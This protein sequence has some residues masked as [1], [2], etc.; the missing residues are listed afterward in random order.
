MITD[1]QK[2][3]F[4]PEPV[5][6]QQEIKTPI[7]QIGRTERPLNARTQTNNRYL[8]SVVAYKSQ[9]ITLW[10]EYITWRTFTKTWNLMFDSVPDGI[11]IP[12]SWTYMILLTVSREEN[13]SWDRYIEILKNTEFYKS[14]FNTVAA[15]DALLYKQDTTII[16]NFT[17]WDYLEVRV[18]QS[19]AA[20]LNAW[21]RFQVVKLS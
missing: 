18:L 5:Q 8:D 11:V 9:E 14:V 4:I 1:P 17:K 15:T 3:E 2:I 20:T 7:S 12:K 13:N 19:W 16:D 10:D 6:V 21:V